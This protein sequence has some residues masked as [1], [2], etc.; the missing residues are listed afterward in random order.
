MSVMMMIVRTPFDSV[1]NDSSLR[2]CS[3]SLGEQS[4]SQSLSVFATSDFV[5]VQ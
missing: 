1:V 3:P 4:A 2:N 5:N